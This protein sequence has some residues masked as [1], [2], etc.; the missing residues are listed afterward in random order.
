MDSEGTS[1][2]SFLQTDELDEAGP[3]ATGPGAQRDTAIGITKE[4]AIDPVLRQD[5]SASDRAD[6][7][8]APLTKITPLA[9]VRPILKRE[10]SAPP[11]PQ[12]HPPPEPPPVPV[13]D[14]PN[15]TDSLSL[16]QLRKLV[17][18]MPTRVEPVPYDFK[19]EDT[20]TLEEEI[21]ELFGYSQEE[22]VFLSEAQ[23]SYHVKRTEFVEEDPATGKSSPHTRT[24]WC[25]TSLEWRK[26]FLSR[27]R[28]ILL[29]HRHTSFTQTLQALVYIALGCWNETAGIKIAEVQGA[30]HSLD[31]QEH[32]KQD[33]PNIVSPH[34]SQLSLIRTNV[35]LIAQNIG[36]ETLY[37]I[38]KTKCE[39]QINHNQSIDAASNASRGAN[40]TPERPMWAILTLMCLITD[41]ARRQEVDECDGVLR[42]AVLQLQPGMLLYLT[43]ILVDMR[44]G[45]SHTLP[46]TKFLVLYRNVCLLQLGGISE[47]SRTKAALDPTWHDDDGEETH[48]PRITASPLDYHVFRQE[49]T[50]K[51]PAFSPPP[52]AFPLEPG[53]TSI[54]PPLSEYLG[55]STAISASSLGAGPANINGNGASILYQPV[56][57]ATPAPSPPP[58]PA[59]PGGKGIK[60]QNY[61]TNQMFPF[62]Y[63]P[64][65]ESSNDIGGKG[66][67][68]IQDLLAGRK[69]RGSDIPTSILEAADLFAQRMRATRAMKQLWEE[70]VRF[71]KYE[72]GYVSMIDTN[73]AIDEDAQHKNEHSFTNVAEGLGEDLRQRL[74][75]VEA[76]YVSNFLN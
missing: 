65:E 69:W 39:E 38:L 67:T 1:K 62:L 14:Q 16:A 13:Q 68:E 54:L 32:S 19:Y 25:E 48:E 35:D 75:A 22:R 43:T 51:Y 4:P 30:V 37:N 55:R 73:K 60:K 28:P 58:S 18:D 71:M 66:S 10:R 57:I 2:Q 20:A 8:Q 42:K 11:P 31:G 23:F 56:H 33:P 63:P 53:S 9:A 52:P 12:H 50:S 27:F 40:W 49:I 17:T 64:L 46:P 76:F 26:T 61:Q 6:R 34:A 72:R 41:I 45:D 21:E 59:G 29:D 15:P 44:W 3:V 70:R 74:E 47:I 7:E 24:D 5:D 36:V